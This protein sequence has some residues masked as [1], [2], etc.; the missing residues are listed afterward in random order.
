[1]S[2]N[3]KYFCDLS[4]N[5]GA[6]AFDAHDYADAGHRLI[7]LKVSQ[8]STYADPPWTKWASEARDHGLSVLL[9]H[10][11]DNTAAA[12]VQARWFVRL[13]KSWG[14]YEHSRDHVCLDVE[15]LGNLS[16][17][18]G[19]RKDYERVVHEA[20]FRSLLVYSDAGY[21]E[22]F[23]EGLRPE[24]GAL[25]VAGF[26]TYPSGWWDHPWAHQY[27]QTGQVAGVAGAC[28]LSVIL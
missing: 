27:S 12:D 11:A 19:F 5:N 8:G 14:R 1:M 10:F 23:G 21:F 20:G 4:S 28:D 3:A 17:P 22:Q 6:D 15:Q 2:E 13:V 18:V 9:Y 7:G 16:D 24:R 25:W 26:P